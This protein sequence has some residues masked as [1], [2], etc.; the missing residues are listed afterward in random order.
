[1]TSVLV[2]SVHT[3]FDS[4]IWLRFC[5]IFEKIFR[6]IDAEWH[7][8]SKLCESKAVGGPFRDLFLSL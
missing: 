2:P 3:I 1:M 7:L 4:T 8:S 5:T 6:L